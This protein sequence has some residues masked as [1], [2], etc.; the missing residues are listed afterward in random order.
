MA[1]LRFEH[2]LLRAT[3][4]DIMRMHTTSLGRASLLAA[5]SLALFAVGCNTSDVE[6]SSRSD[7]S[8]TETTRQQL[9]EESQAYLFDGP[10]SGPMPNYQER[11]ALHLINRMRMDPAKFRIT[12]PMSN[13]PYPP[14]PPFMYDVGLAE[15]SRWQA[16]HYLDKNCGE[17]L[18]CPQSNMAQPAAFNSCCTIGIRQGK[19][20]CVSDK[21]ACDD[22]QATQ[23]EER[24]RMLVRGPSTATSENGSGTQVSAD[25][26]KNYPG[27]AAEFFF[28]QPPRAGTAF[29]SNRVDAIG[30]AQVRDRITPDKC[31]SCP[32]GTC[33]NPSN[34]NTTCNEEANPTCSGICMGGECNGRCTTEGE[35]GSEKPLA[36][37]LPGSEC[38]PENFPVGFYTDF[39]RGISSAPTPTL[40]DG[41][42]MKLG[43]VSQQSPFGYEPPEE[44]PQQQPFGRTPPKKMEFAVNYYE[45]AGPAQTA[46]LV[47][48]GSCQQLTKVDKNPS[49]SGGGPTPGHNGGD[50]GATPA[51]DAAIPNDTGGSGRDTNVGGSDAGGG[52]SRYIGLR[53]ETES[54]VSPGC[55][56]YVFSV[57]DADGFVHT[58]PSHGSLGVRVKKI[59]RKK[60]GNTQVFHMPAP[61]NDACPIWSPER[62]DTSCLPKVTQCA[63]GQTRPCYTG[64]ANTRGKGICKTGTETCKNGRWSGVCQNEV[65]PEPQESCGNGKDDNCNG[66]VDEGC[67]NSGGGD[68]GGSGEDTGSTSDDAGSPRPGP[69]VGPTR[70]DDAGGS[71]DGENPATG[72]TGTSDPDATTPGANPGPNVDGGTPVGGE[73]DGEDDASGCGCSGTGG[74]P[75]QWPAAL[76]FLVG[77]GWARLR[78][79]T[80]R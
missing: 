25:R 9:G 17:E 59:T 21:V 69:D 23:E 5:L 16:Q 80:R 31:S 50:A 3:D 64:R 55:H 19:A 66:F 74:G 79:R 8:T 35:T 61:P 32:K 72:D 29:M 47:L 58:Y 30:V 62:P 15:A 52:Q 49:T 78:R 11:V 41:I 7:D 10:G 4:T 6:P 68:A 51:V 46:N 77:L 13:R 57:E 36:C 26:A 18:G 63:S 22:D 28:R 75:V 20:Q 24:W 53:Y 34:G 65:R 76:I 60:D 54:T 2:W 48:D 40:L 43:Y 70:G 1:A 71:N 14:N 12:P 56:R 38:Q 37:D 42:H 67:G 44:K 33:T 39:L 27:L 73:D 45:P